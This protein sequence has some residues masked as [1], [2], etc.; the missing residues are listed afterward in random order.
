[1]NAADLKNTVMFY[2]LGPDWK[3]KIEYYVC[4]NPVDLPI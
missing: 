2:V 1:L 3:R 4:K